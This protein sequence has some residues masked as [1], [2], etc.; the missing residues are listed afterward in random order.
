MKGSASDRQIMS[1]TSLPR[2]PQS[3]VRVGCVIVFL[4]GVGVLFGWVFEISTLRSVFPDLPM[5]S[6][7]T[8]LLLALLGIGLAFIA[9]D[10]PISG[11]ERS[12]LETQA[13]WRWVPRGMALFAMFVGS[14]RLGAS[15]LGVELGGLDRHLKL[16]PLDLNA[17]VEQVKDLTR[18]RWHDMPRERGVAVE[19][20]TDLTTDLPMVMG[21]ESEIREALTNLVFNAVDA[22]PN[23]GRVAVRTRVKAID[24]GSGADTPATV[25]IEVVDTGVGMNEDT[26]CRCLEPFFTTKGERGSGLGLAMVYGVVQ[27]HSAEIDIES[28]VGAGTTV[29]VSF[30]SSTHSLAEPAQIV[31]SPPVLPRLSILVIDDDPIFTKSLRDV[32]EADGHVV[33]TTGGGK[34]GIE[35]FRQAEKQGE[36]FAVVLTDL[37]MPH[38]DGHKVA[39]AIKERSRSTPVILLTGWGQRL[40]IDDHMPPNVDRVL[41]KPPRLLELRAALA[42]SV[43]NGKAPTGSA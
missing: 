26:R 36:R 12:A 19:M 28:V 4:T 43:S 27:R 11:H 17:L 30:P 37:G 21:V 20:H 16:T 22:M 14:L 34:E 18:A 5:M 40:P 41:G 10:A 15:L 24:A 8:A 42:W 13:N 2:W 39:A 23:G 6:P 31:E 7:S 3:T 29:R 25:Q 33:V 9:V 38:I 1:A 32:L 35:A